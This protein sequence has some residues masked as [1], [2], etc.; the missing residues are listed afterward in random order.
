M[1]A[2][3]LKRRE[4]KMAKAQNKWMAHLAAVRKENPKIK[5]VKEIA[6]IAKASY[7]K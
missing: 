3:K 5:D 4:R 7:K 6:K 2:I 1:E